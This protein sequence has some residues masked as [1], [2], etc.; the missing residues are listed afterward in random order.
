MP[1]PILPTRAPANMKNSTIRNSI[2]I[3]VVAINRVFSLIVGHK[4]S[5]TLPES[6]CANPTLFCKIRNKNNQ[7]VIF[8]R[9]KHGII[10][11]L[12]LRKLQ[13]M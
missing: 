4:D 7:I 13:I 1:S 11:L 10:G 9:Q 2:K 6:S 5:L 12:Y 3:K 8:Y